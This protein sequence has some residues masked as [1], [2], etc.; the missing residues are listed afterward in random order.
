MPNK[1]G[2]HTMLCSLRN[3]LCQINKMKTAIVTGAAGNL[4]EAVVNKFLADGYKVMG[5]VNRAR[6]KERNN[7]LFEEMTVD[8]INESAAAGFV[9]SVISKHQKIDV[10]VLTVGGFAMGKIADTKTSDIM[11][12]YKLNFETAYNIARPVFLQMM[13]Q[14]SGRIF[15]VGSRPAL[16]GKSSKGMVAYGLAKSLIF[17][18]AEMMNEEAKGHDVVTAVVVPSTIDTPQNRKSM[19]DA[20]YSK[21]VK[22]EAIADVIALY[23][24]DS[25]AIVRETV[26]KVYGNG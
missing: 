15:L 3:F 20:D 12:Q 21:W 17:R 1:V 19:P 10:A 14:N 22:T 13:K 2:L 9:E 5:T 24:G 26:I 23:A 8:L 16:D 18:L 25:T 11:A 6:V 7:D 4:G